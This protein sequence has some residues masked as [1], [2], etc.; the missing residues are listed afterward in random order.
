MWFLV[1][2]HIMAMHMVAWAT[3]MGTGVS[4][5]RL[6]ARMSDVGAFTDLSVGAWLCARLCAGAGDPER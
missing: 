4:V 3:R 5:P 1:H 6:G 2:L